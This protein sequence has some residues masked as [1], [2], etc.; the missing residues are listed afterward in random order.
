MI[1]QQS[2]WIVMEQLWKQS[3]QTMIQLFHTLEK[4]PGW[5][6]STVNT[7]LKR[8][9]DKKIIRYEEGKAKLYYPCIE[10]E[11]AV[12]SE[13]NRLI[14]RIYNGSVSMMMNTLV[15]NK[16]MT[17]EEIQELYELLDT[18]NND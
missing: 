12:L 10:K 18:I 1:L 7:M 3:P 2:E 13:T 9:V 17:K 8:M 5:S 15:K 6:K 14:D 11:T 4:E 16:K